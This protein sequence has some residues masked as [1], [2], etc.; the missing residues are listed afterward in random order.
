MKR[1]L[2][3]YVKVR[4]SRK[5]IV[6]PHIYADDSFRLARRYFLTILRW[7][8]W[9]W[10]RKHRC[11]RKAADRFERIERKE[12]DFSRKFA[13]FFNPRETSLEETAYTRRLLNQDLNF[14]L[15]TANARNA[16]IY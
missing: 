6:D 12:G 11:V 2:T 7:R 5:F 8:Y 13:Q 1:R 14:K 15:N 4:V 3:I 10:T 16:H 9:S